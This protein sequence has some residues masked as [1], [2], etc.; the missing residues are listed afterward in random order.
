MGLVLDV[1]H[2]VA[3]L[4]LSAKS[5]RKFGLMIGGAFLL[6][7]MI[8]LRKRWDAGLLLSFLAAGSALALLGAALPKVLAIVY[9]VWMTL[10]LAIGWCVS[11]LLL[12]ILFSLAIV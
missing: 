6:L 12:I 2:E 4:D 3:Q 5:L 10:S 7:A 9:R 1:K 11:R 8:A